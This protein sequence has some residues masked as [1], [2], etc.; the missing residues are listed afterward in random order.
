[1]LSQD[2][3]LPLVHDHS[4]WGVNGQRDGH[5]HRG[6]CLATVLWRASTT[7]VSFLDV[8]SRNPPPATRARRLLLRLD[9]LARIAGNASVKQQR[10]GPTV[11]SWHIFT[12]QVT[13]LSFFC[14]QFFMCASISDDDVYYYYGSAKDIVMEWQHHLLTTMKIRTGGTYHPIRSL[15]TAV[16]KPD[17]KR[18]VCASCW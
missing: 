7:A 9:A 1:M 14:L 8:T 16:H 17:N 6:T 3:D 4:P 13:C 18:T 11:I 12:S 10:S 15:R 5:W 2:K